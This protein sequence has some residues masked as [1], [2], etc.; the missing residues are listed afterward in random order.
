MP[1]QERR[2]NSLTDADLSSISDM[3]D[4]RMST[5][6]ETIG[7]DTTTPDSR[8]E[9]REDHE[10]VRTTRNAKG[11]IIGAFLIGIGTV[12]ATWIGSFFVKS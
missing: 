1:T 2:Q 12:I 7:Y 6:F 4:S 3:F 8:H 9:I 11:T 5:L 10:F